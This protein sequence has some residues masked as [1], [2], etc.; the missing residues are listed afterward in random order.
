MICT[1]GDTSDVTWWRELNLQLRAIIG[2]D[3]RI[4][5]DA[6]ADV[7]ADAYATIAGLTVKQ[8][9]TAV[10]QQLTEAGALLGDVRPIQHP[11]KFY[12]K[13]ERPLEIVT[14]RQWYIRNGGRDTDLRAALV[15]RAGE[16]TWHP[17]TC[18]T[19]TRTGSRA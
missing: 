18:A 15:A 6:P 4:L 3:G 13:G 12:E 16:L 7:D 10:V 11:V 17:P 5:A 19:A 9:Q 8:A 14:S 1:F 2:R